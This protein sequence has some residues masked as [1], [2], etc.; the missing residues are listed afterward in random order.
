MYPKLELP[1]YFDQESER[2]LYR[3]LTLDDVTEWAEFFLDNPNLAYLGNAFPEDTMEASKTWID[4]QLG[5]YEE[6]GVGHLAVIEKKSGALIGMC[7]LLSRE[8]EG[9]NEYEVAYS[10]KPAY[11]RQGFGTEMARRMKYFGIENKL[12]PRF[13]SMIHPE[14]I[15]SIKVAENNGMSFLFKS[16][17]MEMPVLVYGTKP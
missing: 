15:G 11:W 13:V 7:G 16:S 12:A 2:L 14:N 8:I 10:I 9:Q 1:S 6:M 17:Y 4:R 3:K 5:R